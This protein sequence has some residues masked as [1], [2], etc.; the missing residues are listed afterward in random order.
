MRVVLT[1]S[2]GQLGAYVMERLA[3]EGHDV[4]AWSGSERGDRSGCALQPVDLRD[5]RATEQSL[6]R[7][8]PDVIIHL[9]AVSSIEGAR[10]DPARAWAI[11]IEATERLANWCERRDRRL[12]YTSTDLVFD[13]SR[14]WSREG[15]P[16]EPTVAYGRTKLEAEA[17]VLGV[18]RGLVARLSLLYGLSRSGR[19]SFFDQMAAALRRGEP[20]TFFED[21][22]RTPLHFMTAA[23]ALIRLAESDVAGV[24]HVGGRERLSRFEMAR[25]AAIALGYDSSLVRANRLR[26]VKFAEPRPADVSLDTSRMAAILPDLVRPSVEESLGRA[27]TGP[28]EV[29]LFKRCRPSS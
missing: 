14:S 15:D 27:N 22:F 23:E 12:L 29:S 4:S 11:N 17:G 6:A 7:H 5:A 10:L 24:V 1:G 28:P 16:A 3:A 21:E 20:Q 9:A 26:D 25:R 13:G 8:D 2:S 19:A 18:P